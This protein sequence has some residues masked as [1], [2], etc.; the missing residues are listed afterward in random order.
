M[1]TEF[2][3]TTAIFFAGAMAWHA[4]THAALAAIKTDQP[5]RSLGIPMTPARNAAAAAVW[6]GVSLALMRYGAKH[7]LQLAA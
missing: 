5:H 2:R 7:P 4:L 3:K 6:A 1:T